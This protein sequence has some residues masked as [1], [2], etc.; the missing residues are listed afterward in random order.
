MDMLFPLNTGTI[1]RDTSLVPVGFE[2][3]LKFT[4]SI[5]N[6]GMDFYQLIETKNVIPLRGKTVTLSAYVA[7]TNGKRQQ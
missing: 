6:S 5:K 4:S 2:S 7:G 3:S 1:S